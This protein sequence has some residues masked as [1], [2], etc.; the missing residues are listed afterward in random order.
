MASWFQDM[1]LQLGFSSVAARFL[2]KEQRLDSPERL[3]VLQ[4]E[5]IDDIC[6]GMRKP[7]RNN[8]NRMPDRGQQV[9]VIAQEN[10]KLAI[11]LFHHQWGCTF[12]WEVMRV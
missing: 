4:E 10:L 11:F 7:G 2:I 1:Y 3:R 5:V 12:D 9:S 8:A 6:N